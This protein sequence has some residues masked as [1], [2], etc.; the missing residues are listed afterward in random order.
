MP[1]F[2]RFVQ[3]L[4]KFRADRLSATSG[5]RVALYFGSDKKPVSAEAAT[6]QQLEGLPGG[7]VSAAA[8]AARQTH[9]VIVVEGLIGT[10]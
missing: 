10:G 7:L 3:T 2:D 1:Q 5:E 4:Y 8:E 6:R 9:Q